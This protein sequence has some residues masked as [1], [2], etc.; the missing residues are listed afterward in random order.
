LDG[1]KCIYPNT[2]KESW[3]IDTEQHYGI[4]KDGKF[5]TKYIP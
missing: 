2:E 1:P 3:N 4:I 5:K